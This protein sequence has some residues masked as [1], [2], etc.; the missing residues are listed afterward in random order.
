MSVWIALSQDVT[1]CHMS[2]V[3]PG[4]GGPVN[5]GPGALLPAQD[6]ADTIL[7]H[8]HGMF[9]KGKTT[10]TKNTQIHDAAAKGNLETLKNLLNNSS[11]TLDKDLINFKDGAQNTVSQKRTLA[12]SAAPA[13]GRSLWTNRSDGVPAVQWLSSR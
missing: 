5:G 9:N 13:L 10:L 3:F 7:T 4:V 8:S 12:Q 1:A 6:T 11:G 2:W